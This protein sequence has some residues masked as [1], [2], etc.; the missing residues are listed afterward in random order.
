[1]KLNQK[2]FTMV[3]LL[4][5]V[6]I[7]SILSGV[8]ITAVT[9]YQAKARQESY[10]AM[11]SSAFSAAQNYIQE[12]GIIV[13]NDGSP[14]EIEIEDLVEG[15]YLPKLQDPSS[16]SSYCHNGSKVFVSKKKGSGTK[17]DKYTYLVVIKC[18]NYKSSHY[19]TNAVT[20]NK[21]L[22]QGVYYYS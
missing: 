15:E 12:R 6:A 5:A 20:G 16:K 19:E 13:P 3:E 17:L 22:K 18:K 7:L 4:A 1:M 11:E 2:G 9:K 14:I 21:E 10:K 8:A